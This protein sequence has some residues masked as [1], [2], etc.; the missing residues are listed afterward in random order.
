MAGGDPGAT[1]AAAAFD[2]RRA[3][4][5][6]Q[7]KS[8]NKEQIDQAFAAY[9]AWYSEDPLHAEN[10]VWWARPLIMPMADHANDT[11]ELIELSKQWKFANDPQRYGYLFALQAEAL[12]NLGKPK[13][14]I[15]ALQEGLDRDPYSAGDELMQTLVP[16]LSPQKKQKEIA[17][18]FGM[19]IAYCPD[20]P[21]IVESCLK[22]RIATLNAVK[23]YDAALADARSLFNVATMAHTAD[24]ITILDRQFLL[25]NM[26]DRSKVD[27]FRAEQTAGA[28][29]AP[30]GT[31]PR[32]SPLLLGI[33]ID[34]SVYTDS[35]KKMPDDSLKALNRHA[36]LLLI[37]G[38]TDEALDIAKQA[39][40][41]S[42]DAKEIAA[43]NE[44][45]ARC[46]KAQDGTIGRANAWIASNPQAQ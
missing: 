22:Q 20:E 6:G 18:L 15:A 14:A 44:L 30:S 4:L 32:T 34:E 1:S 39:L 3:S 36:T 42:T 31:V 28:A 29:P 12:M 10:A 9:K 37:A 35:L 16:A 21:I 24:A 17:D 26:D 5:E 19:A 23:Q 13:E 27:Q 38:K 45:I 25:P 46:Y 8:G 2:A 7:L 33:K 11:L 40:A 41:Q 43:A